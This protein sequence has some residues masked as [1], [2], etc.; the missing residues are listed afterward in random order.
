MLNAKELNYFN[1]SRID[2]NIF[3]DS[4]GLLHNYNVWN[5]EFRSLEFVCFLEFVIWNFQ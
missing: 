2:E 4:F 3:F 1:F 5:F